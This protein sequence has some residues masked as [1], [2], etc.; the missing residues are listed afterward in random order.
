M[1][2]NITSTYI[3]NHII[4]Q[5]SIECSVKKSKNGILAIWYRRQPLNDTDIC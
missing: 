5:T 1:I 3:D 2:E 4:H